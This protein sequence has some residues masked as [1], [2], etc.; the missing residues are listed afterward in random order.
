MR[1][2]LALAAL[3]LVIGCAKKDDPVPATPSASP[4]PAGKQAQAGGGNTVAGAPY[5]P[6]AGAV[7]PVQGGDFGGGGG[8]VQQAALGRARKVAGGESNT[9]HGTESGGD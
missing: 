4:S 7:S 3:A 2:I 9:T 1:V 6:G 8:G 5:V